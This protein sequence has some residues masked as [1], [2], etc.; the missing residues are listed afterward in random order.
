MTKALARISFFPNTLFGK[1]RI[2]YN[3]YRPA[4]EVR[5]DMLNSGQIEFVDRDKARAGEREIDAI[6][7]FLHPKLVEPFLAPG[8]KFKFSEGRE[9]LGEGVIIEVLK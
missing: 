3:K 9:P 6:I 8:K 7:T 4:F 2:Y 5:D 1:D